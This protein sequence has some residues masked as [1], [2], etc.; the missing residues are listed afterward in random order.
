MP[1][2]LLNYCFHFMFDPSVD[3]LLNIVTNDITRINSVVLYFSIASAVHLTIVWFD[4]IVANYV[5]VIPHRAH[6]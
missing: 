4:Y 1:K 2:S 6:R 5:T 3:K